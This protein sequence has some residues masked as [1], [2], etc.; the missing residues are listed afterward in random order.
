MSLLSFLSNIFGRKAPETEPQPKKSAAGEPHQQEPTATTRPVSRPVKP[1]IETAATHALPETPGGKLRV[2]IGFDFG[3]NTSKVV[4]RVAGGN[5]AQVVGFRSKVSGLPPYCYSS[6]MSCED[7]A[8]YW[9]PEADARA[10]SGDTVLRSLKT[11]LTCRAKA[12]ARCLRGGS[13]CV[14]EDTIRA[15]GHD[16]SEMT[17]S[18]AVTSFIAQALAHAKAGVLRKIGADAAVWTVNMCVPTSTLC[19]SAVIQA[20]EIVLHEG[21][22]LSDALLK[23]AG[24]QEFSSREIKRR[25]E[26]CVLPAKREKMTFVVSEA[27]AEVNAYIHSSAVEMR[28]YAV[29]DIGAGTSDI[30]FFRPIILPGRPPS[31]RWFG[32]ATV[33]IAGDAVDEALRSQCASVWPEAYGTNGSALQ[34]IIRHS[35]EKWTAGTGLRL[36][37]PE[38]DEVLSWGDGFRAVSKPYKDLRHE[39]ERAWGEAYRTEKGTAKWQDVRV[40]IGGGSS[41]LPWIRR[42]FLRSIHDSVGDWEEEYIHGPAD[43]EYGDAATPSDFYRLAVAYGLSTRFGELPGEG[44]LPP[45]DRPPSRRRSSNIIEWPDD[46]G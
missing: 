16:P 1:T 7:G 18:V 37:T 11:C 3:T 41:G 32:S 40:L 13:G 31:V 38:R 15:F 23:D 12:S 21:N 25:I 45:M 22:R 43:L 27:L 46:P 8:L 36:R 33:P 24:G 14:Y 5:V 35:K 17:P 44:F 28:K 26:S 10:M 4:Y 39:Y 19:D 29:V 2:N 20:Y 6:A 42:E 9:G 34:E 30:S